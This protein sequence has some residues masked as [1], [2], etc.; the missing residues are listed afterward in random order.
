MAFV[1]TPASDLPEVTI[2]DASFA[3]D[4]VAPASLVETMPAT[5][6]TAAVAA[7]SGRRDLPRPG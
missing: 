4:G 6:A 2:P 1:C 7:T 5:T 3:C